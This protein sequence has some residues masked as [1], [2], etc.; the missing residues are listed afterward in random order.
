MKKRKLLLGFGALS[1]IVT[2][3]GI[4][5]SCGSGTDTPAQSDQTRLNAAVTAFN[6]AASVSAN[7][8][9]NVTTKASDTTTMTLAQFTNRYP[10][11]ASAVTSRGAT[12]SNIS[13]VSD[14]FDDVKGT[15]ELSITIKVNELSKTETVTVLGFAKQALADDAAKAAYIAR[16]L[17]KASVSQRTATTTTLLE[18]TTYT[19][20]SN[21]LFSQNFTNLND[22]ITASKDSTDSVINGTLTSVT[23]V[24]NSANNESA[25]LKVTVDVTVGG[26][27]ATSSE[28]TLLGFLA[29]DEGVV[30]AIEAAL[31]V[32]SAKK[33]NTYFVQ[34]TVKASEATAP[35]VEQFK[36]QWPAFANKITEREATINS[37]AIKANSANDTEGKL[38][39]DVNYTYKTASKTVS[40][41][42]FGFSSPIVNPAVTIQPKTART[43]TFPLNAKYN[44]E[45]YAFEFSASYGGNSNSANSRRLNADLFRV[46]ATGQPIYEKNSLELLSPSQS[47]YQLLYADS[48]RITK[49]D[50]TVVTYNNDKH[51]I[52]GV[53][54]GNESSV[55]KSS[56]DPASINN[57]Q[58]FS[59]LTGATKLQISIKKGFYWTD[60]NG[61]KTDYEV[62][63]EDYFYSFNRTR[64][65]EGS[66]RHENGGSAELDKFMIDSKNVKTRFA[67]SDHYPN[68]Y[69][70]EIFS[71]DAK[72][73]ANKEQ[74]LQ[75]VDG[76][77]YLTYE[78]F[79]SK[80]AQFADMFGKEFIDSNE[81]AAAPSAYLKAKHAEL[82]TALGYSGAAPTGIAYEMGIYSYGLTY[83]DVLYAGPY[84]VSEDNATTKVQV[85][86]TNNQYV[87][88]EFVNSPGSINTIQVN[89][90]ESEASIFET[91][92]FEGFRSGD[93]SSLS[94]SQLTDT[95]KND[96]IITSNLSYVKELQSQNLHIRG[97]IVTVPNKDID[98]KFYNDNFTK[99]VFG[100]TISEITQGTAKTGQAMFAGSGLVF[101]SI[102]ESAINWERINNIFLGVDQAQAWRSGLAPDGFIGGSDQSTSTKKTV[103]DY[104]DIV[105]GTFVLNTNGEIVATSVPS[106]N[107]TKA[108]VAVSGDIS[109]QSVDYEQAK[110]SMKELLDKAGIA[111]GQK[112][113]WKMYHNTT[114]AVSE[115]LQLAYDAIIKLIKS[116]DDR[117]DVSFEISSQPADFYKYFTEGKGTTQ[118]AGWGYDYNGLGSG[119]DGLLWTKN[120]HSLA[121]LSLYSND[122]TN[123]FQNSFPEFTKMAKELKRA[124]ASK[125]FKIGTHTLEADGTYKPKDPTLLAKL[126][127]ASKWVELTNSEAEYPATLF[128]GYSQKADGTWEKIDSSAQTATFHLN[129][130][131]KNTN[132]SLVKLGQEITTLLGG[133]IVSV[134]GRFRYAN[135]DKPTAT[136]I[137]TYYE[138]PMSPAGL[139]DVVDIRKN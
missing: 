16:L 37:V 117:L 127:D 47:Y 14:S 108:T 129:Y 20:I 132:E 112:V 105:N 113:T 30:S 130:Q 133:Y 88:K 34:K 51:E 44:S 67:T 56:S 73:F 78:S 121:A 49:N 103:K 77:T 7:V 109:V 99:L 55:F 110:K 72:K 25:S 8:T 41:D 116:L 66:T 123:E 139:R 31:K 58:F 101:R 114:S 69:L 75:Q 17:S 81:W 35:S 122:E 6:N 10:N 62:N 50:G 111:N 36:N 13:V 85:F 125:E 131:R 21:E 2:S 39:L 40:L 59:D 87:D 4:A 135:I 90:D 115:K 28:I 84:Y 46:K 53:A 74:F 57:P 3:A 45:P 97:K 107:K 92:L 24:P 76:T 118:F 134:S 63:A 32:V 89:F 70:Y 80:G 119:I 82:H 48:V 104:S 79:D 5:I 71:V 9:S 124:V 11:L 68:G 1:A 43:I 15:V 61:A 93:N 128:D 95:R 102:I 22:L 83:K 96:S 19:T 12:I 33:S 27:K 18:A 136:V 98:G 86:K 137:N 106:E 94:Y 64:M 38:T 52:Q 26:S 54:T 60:Y 23:L 29:S 120:T 126:Q 138:F 100:S 42:V 91:R 65:L